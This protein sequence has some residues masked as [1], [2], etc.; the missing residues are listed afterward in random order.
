[1]QSVRT[2]LFMLT[3][4]SRIRNDCDFSIFCGGWQSGARGDTSLGTV[5]ACISANYPQPRP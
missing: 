2:G 1:V 5:C 4:S 3:P